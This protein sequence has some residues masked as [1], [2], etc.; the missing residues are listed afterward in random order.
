MSAIRKA[1]SRGHV[2]V[3][4]APSG[5]GKTTLCRRIL[6]EDEK[7]EISVSHTTRSP[8]EGEKDGVHYHF[9]SGK[10]FRG[11]AESDGFLEHAE[12]GGNAYG[13]S[14]RA[15]EAPLE[16]GRDVVL[17]IEVQGAAQ[18]RERRPDA[19]LIFLLPPSLEI[20]EERL[21]GRG[22]DE[23]AVIQRRMA[24]VDREL[25]AAT[26][27]DYAVVNDDLETAVRQVLDVIAAVRKGRGDEIEASFGREGVLSRWEGRTDA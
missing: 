5:T 9:A 12:Y 25:A 6:E 21:R 20:L 4:A 18:V 1:A 16:S 7:L 19:C 10:G 27:F 23:E 17:E 15:I 26:L 11:L 13:T 22:T 3:I 2:F 14:W 8:R 24:L